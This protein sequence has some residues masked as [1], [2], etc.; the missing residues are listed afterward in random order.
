MPLPL[1][2]SISDPFFFLLL[3]KIFF[4][5]L[6]LF[7]CRKKYIVMA[8]RTSWA[9]ANAL[10]TVSQQALKT[11]RVVVMNKPLTKRFISTVR[12][13]NKSLNTNFQPFDMITDSSYSRSRRQVCFGWH[14]QLDVSKAKGIVYHI[15]MVFLKERELTACYFIEIYSRYR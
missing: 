8:T 4:F 5:F 9:K 13:G 1:S 15:K 12:R 2:F 10:F 6:P 3:F 14:C 7:R 11:K